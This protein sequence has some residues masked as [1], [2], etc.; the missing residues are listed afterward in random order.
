MS[1]PLADLK[2]TEHGECQHCEQPIIR[3][4]NTSWGS[5]WIHNPRKGF[6]HTLCVGQYTNVA[7]P[8]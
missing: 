5:T 4:P 2:Q 7:T 3:W 6:R 8:K 1:D